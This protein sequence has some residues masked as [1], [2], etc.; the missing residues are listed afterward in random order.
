VC[1][2]SWPRTSPHRSKVPFTWP[3]LSIWRSSAG[4]GVLPKNSVF[5]VANRARPASSNFVA[6]ASGCGTSVTSRGRQVTVQTQLAQSDASFHWLGWIVFGVAILF[7]VG[8]QV[9]MWMRRSDSQQ[10]PEAQAIINRGSVM[11]LRPDNPRAD[12][13]YNTIFRIRSQF[14]YC[15][16]LNGQRYGG[17]FA[18][19]TDDLHHANCS[20]NLTAIA[21]RW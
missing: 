9:R 12:H 17:I 2:L 10:W 20:G 6:S 3:G 1:E 14:G 8:R 7:F 18:F 19:I 4:T 5:P 21:Y 15:F 16:Q 11:E 13:T